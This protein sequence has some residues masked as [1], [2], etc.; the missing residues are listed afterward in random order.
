MGAIAFYKRLGYQVVETEDGFLS[1]A[2]Q[3]L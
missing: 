2:L 3:I 1:F